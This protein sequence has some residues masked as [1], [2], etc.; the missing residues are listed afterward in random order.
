MCISTLS[1]CICTFVVTKYVEIVLRWEIIF[2]VFPALRRSRFLRNIPTNITRYKSWR[3]LRMTMQ[4]PW[5]W[6]DSW[7]NSLILVNNITDKHFPGDE[8]H[9]RWSLHHVGNSPSSDQC[10]HEEADTSIQAQCISSTVSN[11]RH[12][13][14][15]YWRHRYFVVIFLNNF[16]H[17]RRQ[18]SGPPSRRERQRKL[19]RSINTMHGVPLS[20][21]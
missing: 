6:E 17:I 18:K 1:S 8:N 9:C 16:H 11:L 15:L 20:D 19:S 14:W 2:V 3:T 13:W 21:F 4:L 10:N 12:L 5:V 7:G